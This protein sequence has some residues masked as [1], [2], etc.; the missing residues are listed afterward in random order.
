MARKIQLIFL[1]VFVLTML[2]PGC[3][4]IE[5]VLNSEKTKI[6]EIEQ[7]PSEKE[8]AKLLRQLDRK[9]DNPRTHF[10]LGKL[11]QADGLLIQ[12]EVAYRNTLSFDPVH[13]EAQAAR[14]RVLLDSGDTQQAEYSADFY[15]NQ[16]TALASASLRLALAF[17]K[18][19]LDDYALTCY[20]QALNRAPTSAKINRQIGYYYLSKNDIAQAQ[21]YLRRSFQLNPN[22][23]DVAHELGRLGIA[24]R[25][26]RKAPANTKKIDRIIDRD[27]KDRTR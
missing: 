23:P 12:A 6:K 22:Q 8:K 7:T 14:V 26:P 21:D 9:F 25:I 2:V 4:P 3:G 24:V 18:E 10:R 13:R 15:I 20:R 27:D 19:N 5:K 11:Y 17:Q 1:A 16:S